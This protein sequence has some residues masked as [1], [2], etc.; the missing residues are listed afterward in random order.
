MKKILFLGIG[1][2]VMAACKKSDTTFTG[3]NTSQT[4]T[5]NIASNPD[6]TLLSEAL[7]RTGFTEELTATNSGTLFAPNNNAFLKAGFSTV[8]AIDSANL[9][10]LK[11]L[12]GYHFLPQ[13]V[14]L[15][16]I[17]AQATLYPTAQN[18]SIYLGTKGALG[19]V[20]GW[21]FVQSDIKC[22]NGVIQVIGNLLSPP[23]ANILDYIQSKPN[24]H[25]LTIAI[26]WASTGKT[27]FTSIFSKVGAITFFAP[28]DSAF[29]AAGYATEQSIK[30][31]NPDTIAS[32]LK[33]H[34]IPENILSQDLKSGNSPLTKFGDPLN[35][36]VSSGLSSS[37]TLAGAGNLIPAKIQLAN[38]ICRNGVLYVIDQVLRGPE[39]L[40]S[41]LD[42]NVNL[43]Y[44]KRALEISGLNSLL[45]SASPITVLAPSNTAFQAAGYPS[46]ASIEAANPLV[47]KALINNHLLSKFVNISQLT[48]DKETILQT[49]SGGS[50]FLDNLS[51]NGNLYEGLS[52][53]GTNGN[54]Q[55][56]SGILKPATMNLYATLSSNP[57]YSFLLPLIDKAITGSS[58]IKS[59][60]TGNI[61]YTFFVPNKAAFISTYGSLAALNKLSPV[62]LSD[63]FK[64]HLLSGS[65][66]IKQFTRA[67]TFQ[68]L[69]KELITIS[70]NG[71]P[72]PGD[73]FI[74]FIDGPGNDPNFPIFGAEPSI[75]LDAS[76]QLCTNG[77]IQNI[78]FSIILP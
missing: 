67:R 34:W 68:N 42:R 26:G 60:L 56:V 29:S 24:L 39:N 66:L 74:P 14:F 69:N 62:E 21:V 37:Y 63:L 64:R 3:F 72:V 73:P 52:Q 49:L 1:L 54:L 45:A 48:P 8:S 51:A 40:K 43:T 50:V 23:L 31:L 76:D 47:L 44:F 53:T 28:T 61:P 65:F 13:A 7:K 59:L 22:S 77:V 6:F 5:Q 35:F 10:Q 17:P 11:S 46:I 16:D 18:D 70:S 12:I 30:D 78:E 25:L 9:D 75:T 20:N 15:K 19:Y 2:L 4:I 36:Q 71:N 33:L 32:L 57:T 27:D 41:V 38:Q 58:A 55:I